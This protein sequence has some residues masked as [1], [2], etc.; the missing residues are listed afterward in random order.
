MG[1]LMSSSAELVVF[2]DETWIYSKDN[3]IR[4]WQDD[5]IKSARKPEG[6]DGKR[7][8]VVHAGNEQGFINGA[9]LIFASNSKAIDYHFAIDSRKFEERVTKQLIANLPPISLVVMDN[10]SYHSVVTNKI[11]NTLS[12]KQEEH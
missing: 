5:T 11:P 8:M 1:N 7:F 4:S 2:L 9:S 6:Y 12:R 10:A 3:K